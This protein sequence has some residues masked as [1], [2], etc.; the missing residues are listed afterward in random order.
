MSLKHKTVFIVLFIIGSL[1]AFFIVRGFCDYCRI[2][3]QRI[4]DTESEINHIFKVAE[5]YA[6]AAYKPRLDSYLYLH[7]EI[8]MAFA[9]KDRDLLYHLSKD[10]FST[11][12]KEN[13]YFRIMHFH[14]SD[15][16]TLLRMHKPELYGDQV[17]ASRPLIRAVHNLQTRQTG[18][19]VGR[20]GCFYR[21]AQPVY[22]NGK[23]IGA[24]EFGLSP[25]LI[26]DLLSERL[27]MD[28]SLYFPARTMKMAATS[29]LHP[30]YQ[31][32]GE[33]V[34]TSTNQNF[35]FLPS[36][37]TQTGR[38]SQVA[39]TDKKMVVH[40][41]PVLEDH[42]GGPV[43]G[44][45]ALQDI[46]QLLEEKKTFLIQ[47]ILV[48]IML[49]LV[50][51]WCVYF[52]FE[53]ILARLN[54]YRDSNYDLL[55]QLTLEV[56]EHEQTSVAFKK[57][58]ANFRQLIE[59]AGEGIYGTDEQGRI[60]FVNSAA[61]KMTGHS[62]QEILG[63]D[64]HRTLHHSL[65]DGTPYPPEECPILL[66]LQSGE[67]Q[68]NEK[69]VFW[70]KDGT[71]F[72]VQYTSAPL[73]TDDK[74]MGS[75]INFVDIT[76]R[77]KAEQALQTAQQEAEDANRA[78]TVLIKD[79][80]EIMDEM[81]G[82]RDYKTFEHA[83]RVVEISLRVGRELELKED[84]LDALELG[85]LAHDI[86]KVA[87]PDDVLLKPGLFDKQ[88]RYIMEFHPLV[89]A[90]LFA[91]RHHD[92]RVTNIILHHHE[93][94]DGSGYPAG[95]KDNEL[96]IL[97][98]IVAAA[99]VYEALIAKRPYK[100]P[101]SREQALNL[102]DMEVTLGRLDKAVV[103]AIEKITTDWS[104]LEIKRKY[105]AGYIKEL[106]LF[107]RM[108]YFRE[109]LSDFYNYRYLLFLDDAKLLG[110]NQKPYRMTMANFVKLKELNSEFGYAKT[111]Q[112]LDEVGQNVFSTI[113][114]LNEE[115]RHHDGTF[116]LFRR[117]ADYLI[118][119]D[120]L[121]D[122]NEMLEEKVLEH[123]GRAEREWGLKSRFTSLSF[124]EGYPAEKALHVLLS[125]ATNSPVQ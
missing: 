24:L 101:M 1:S 66:T 102:L 79:L 56:H 35:L 50:S 31:A 17:A 52:N 108:T 7:D 107:R 34:L 29:E 100:Q 112:I 45:V 110:K 71:P 104:P 88:D 60:T 2:E 44:I 81:L 87:I 113:E 6:F 115:C 55:E 123:L 119:S 80:F 59:Q 64:H 62:R 28:S 91:H 94:L 38:S 92:D 68:H 96:D 22:H 57:S 49:L 13:P 58:E 43:G 3:N 4:S 37:F 73:L 97:I 122:H 84:E 78:K 36:D 106:E 54:T 51:F 26:V 75:V 46:S 118:Y 121:Y 125:S 93:R 33:T 114:E 90:R 89:G 15:G 124:D 30:P 5:T 16:T 86:G 40:T 25:Q 103:R 18:F 70:R 83:L 105:S 116:L 48:S 65:A 32:L 72:P 53:K 10:Y 109:P 61:L 27:H 98:R 11:L 19:E 95:L 67:L 117:G 21:I 77:K 76:Q 12:Q 20:H 120:C 42:Q 85:C 47:A 82:N 99:D 39:L 69:D 8:I 74:I 9:E 41:M 23:Y 14:L 63:Q 111:D